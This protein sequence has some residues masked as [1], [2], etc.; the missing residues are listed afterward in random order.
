MSPTAATEQA[1]A[2]KSA[3]HDLTAPINQSVNQSEFF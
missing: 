3:E 1:A 2:V